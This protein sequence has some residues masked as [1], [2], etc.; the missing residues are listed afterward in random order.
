[1]A[2]G[3][4]AGRSSEPVTDPAGAAA[5]GVAIPRSV[6]ISYASPDAT[7]AQTIVEH[8]E[9]HGLRCWIAPRDVRAGTQ[10]ADAIVRA[11]NEAK[12]L[13]LVLSANAVA[14]THVGKEV[15]RASSKRKPIIAF[16]IDAAPLSPALE[17]F[18]SESQWIDAAAGVPALGMAAALARLAEAVEQAEP[19]GAA[20]PGGCLRQ[21]RLWCLVLRSPWAYGF[22]L[23][24]M[25]LCQR[26]LPVE[27]ARPVRSSQISRL[28]YCLLST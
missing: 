18:L 25:K 27:W 12:V 16:R 26:R 1:M 6:F 9:S 23:I 4:G 3:E 22:G 13:V 19:G 10:Y 24:T 8:L 5:P 21:R 14:S 28:R 17:Y 2:E 11:I 7:M 20:P 15:E